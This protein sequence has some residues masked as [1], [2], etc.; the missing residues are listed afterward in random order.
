MR[1]ASVR[2]A[3]APVATERLCWHHRRGMKAAHVTAPGRVSVVEVSE[4]PPKVDHAV[5]RPEIVSICGSD[6]KAVYSLPADEYPLVP[7]RS[8]HEVIG[9]IEQVSYGS[10]VVFP[11]EPGERVLA[12]PAGQA[13]MAERF[14]APVDRVFRIPEHPIQEMVMAQPL[15]TV[16][17]GAQ[18]LTNVIAGNVVVIGQGGIGL[19]FDTL[20]RRMGARCVVGVELMPARRKVA[21]R[22]GATHVVDGTA[23]DVAERIRDALDGGLADTVIDATGEPEAINL[24]ARVVRSRGEI[25]F[26]GGLKER[27]FPFDF[28]S[29]HSRQP[30]TR[31]SGAGGRPLFELAINLIANGDVPVDGIITHRYPLA[32]VA[33]AYDA[34]HARAHD[35]IRV[36][37]EPECEESR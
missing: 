36:A 23:G 28:F 12:L 8:G 1:R 26:F 10:R 37:V 24:C 16:I 19:M 2:P 30:E 3:G 34:A 29:F 11:F 25:L 20:L 7:G 35:C 9:V 27:T 33:L 31:F 15:A 17:S 18:K 14:L 32:E 13:G 4:P 22:F 5:V 6:L 21:D